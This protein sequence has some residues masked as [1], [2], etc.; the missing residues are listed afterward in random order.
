MLE[1]LRGRASTR[2]LR[3]FS[4]AAARLCSFYRLAEG[5]HDLDA[6]LTVEAWAEGDA[7]EED[8]AEAEGRAQTAGAKWATGPDAFLGASTWAGTAGADRSQ[9]AGHCGRVRCIF[10]SPFRAVTADAAWRDRDGRTIL[11]LARAASAERSLPGGLL[12]PARL[13]VLS[14]ALEE[15]GCAD[16]ELLSHLRSAGPHVRGCWALDLVLGRG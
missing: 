1:A 4:C 10:G 7:S 8:V 6:I 11:A 3:L 5:S 16:A 2:K 15:A 13:A 9:L 12:D 14:D